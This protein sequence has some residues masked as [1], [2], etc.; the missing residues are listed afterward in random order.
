MN[1]SLSKLVARDEWPEPKMYVSRPN[2]P[3]CQNYRGRK[4]G[5]VIKERALHALD[6]D[7]ER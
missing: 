5:R 7:F 2:A 1:C 3:S 4:R 6:E